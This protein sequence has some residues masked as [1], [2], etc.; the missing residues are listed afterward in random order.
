MSALTM[1]LNV[2]ALAA[3]AFAIVWLWW[4]TARGGLRL[5]AAALAGGLLFI[6]CGLALKA[7]LRAQLGASPLMRDA[8]SGATLLA[9]LAAAALASLCEE[10]G[11]TGALAAYRP[12]IAAD[13]QWLCAFAM[14]YA[15]TEAALVGVF[16]HAQT[17]ALA[18]DPARLAEVLAALPSDSR[19]AL[20]RAIEALGP[21]TGLWLLTERAAAI[22]FQLLFA[23]LVWRGV[24]A[25]RAAPVALAFLL[26]CLADIPA[27][28][29]QAGRLPL[30]WV[31]GLYAVAGIAALYVMRRHRNGT[32]RPAAT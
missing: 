16:A 10:A 13:P 11:R 31:E 2:C 6:A 26:H 9:P 3:L 18:A 32:R 14:G 24:S 8:V 28:L 27:A 25:R 5:H 22:L 23:A 21:W 29:Y 1:T 17:L 15:L 12:R 30:P 19:V 4:R 20:G 7:G